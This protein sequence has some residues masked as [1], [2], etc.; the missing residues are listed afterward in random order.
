MSKVWSVGILTIS[1]DMVALAEKNKIPRS[2]VY[3][4]IYG[5]DWSI[6][7][8]VSTPVKHKKRLDYTKNDLQQAE[9]NGIGR[10]TFISRLLRGW[11]IERAK[12]HIPENLGR[13]SVNYPAGNHQI[14][15]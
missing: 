9:S 10:C 5:M 14:N 6:E 7:R 13:R 3:D 4:R 15:S 8:A 11:D 12:T 2:V 1:A